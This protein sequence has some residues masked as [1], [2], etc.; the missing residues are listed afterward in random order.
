M[1]GFFSDSF[2][3]LKKTST[4]TVSGVMIALAI[5][6]RSLAIQVSPDIRITFAF[7]PIVVIALLYGPVVAIVANVA[8]DFVGYLVDFK[9]ARG[10]NP[11]LLIV[12]ILSAFIYSCFLYRKKLNLI[13]VSVSRIA[14]VIFCNIGLNSYILYKSYYNKNFDV[15]HPDDAFIAWFLPRVVKNLSQL[16]LDIVLLCLILPMV[17]V[18]HRRIFKK[19][20]SRNQL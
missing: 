15:F 4:I 5:I 20:L 14:V 17:E 7:I 9:S 13:L 11:F 10:Y 16:S 19:T 18:A 6:I 8:T 3:E 12:V 1:K 2:G